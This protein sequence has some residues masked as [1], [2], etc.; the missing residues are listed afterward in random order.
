MLHPLW[1]IWLR[2][3]LYAHIA[4]GATGFLCAPIALATKKGGCNHRYWGKIYFWAMTGVAITALILAFA[5]PIWFLAMV[6]V[7]SF[8]AAFAAYRI[9]YLK[10]LN[11]GGRPKPYDWAAALLTFASSATLCL[12][13]IFAPRAMYV[14]LITI[15]G[16]PVSIVSIV[17]GFIGMRLAWNTLQTFLKPPQDKMFW[18]YDH[19][20]G[21]IASY[22]AA[23]TAF[24]SVNLSQWF[25]PA[26][27][28]WLWPTMIG[29]PAIAI[30]SAYYKKKF[31]AS[32]PKVA[33]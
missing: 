24:S 25:G 30:W 9:L 31:A 19:M 20:Q 32:R 23:M 10:D 11:R 2:I 33:A 5:L 18:W 8:Y 13:G 4:C 27:W 21:M 28:V 7:F 22:I 14:G 15:A 12:A 17:F 1:P 16:H 3:L 26:W 29:V 6:S